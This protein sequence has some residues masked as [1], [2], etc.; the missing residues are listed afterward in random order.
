MQRV[1]GLIAGIRFEIPYRFS[2]AFYG[3]F[4]FV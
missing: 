2:P 4:V 1:I 3:G